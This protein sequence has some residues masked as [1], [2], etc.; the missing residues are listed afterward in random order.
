MSSE[1]GMLFDLPPSYWIAVAVLFALLAEAA[2][3]FRQRWAVPAAMVYVTILGWYMLEPINT[4]ETFGTFSPDSIDSAYV[5]VCIFLI[6][7]RIVVGQITVLLAPKVFG[8]TTIDSVPVDQVLRV[9]AIVWVVLAAIG[10]AR[11]N[12]YVM[13]ALFPIESRNQLVMWQR[14]AG[15][16][17]GSF[18][19]AVSAAG[20]VY[21]LVLASFGMLLPLLRNNRSRIL[22]I[23]LILISWPYAFLQG[24]RNVTLAVFLPMMFSFFLF[25][26]LPKYSKIAIGVVGFSFIEWSLRQII[27]FRNVGFDSK[28]DVVDKGHL[29]LNMASELIYVNSFIKTGV[30]QM[31]WGVG[32][33]EELENLIPRFILPDKALIGIDYAIARGFGGGDADIGVH[34]TISTGLIGQGVLEFGPIFGPIVMAIFI[35]LWVGFLA[36][37]WSQGTV[38]RSCLFLVGLGLTFNLGRD[39]T[40]L[41]LWPMIFGYIAV[42]ASE[43]LSRMRRNTRARRIEIVA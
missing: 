43:R 19:F 37:L 10:I 18:G 8:D 3:R 21:V 25:S 42:I 22:C 9:A 27:R 33:L 24:S 2:L 31:R 23:A 26:R 28:D 30:M 36:R 17:A 14:D 41:V 6:A 15:E 40:L 29:G 4:P 16:G 35:A 39:L 1:F 5:S 13:M 7:F 20:Y 38:P 12:G 34:A 32:F 11:M